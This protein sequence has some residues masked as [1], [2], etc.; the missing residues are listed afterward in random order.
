MFVLE[1]KSEVYISN[2]VQDSYIRPK[3]SLQWM[4]YTFV[5]VP[6][7]KPKAVEHDR[8]METVKMDDRH[9]AW[10]EGMPDS[11][12]WCVFPFFFLFKSSL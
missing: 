1:G 4:F 5:Q 3:T 7:Q 11:L 12:E 8:A 10:E 6:G 9:L 2:A